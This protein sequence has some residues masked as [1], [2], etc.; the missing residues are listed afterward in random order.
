ML[1][2]LLFKYLSILVV[3]RDMK[4]EEGVDKWYENVLRIKMMSSRMISIFKNCVG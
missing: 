1:E 3:K 2:G 4:I